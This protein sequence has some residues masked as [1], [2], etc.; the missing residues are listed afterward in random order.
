MYFDCIHQVCHGQGKIS[1]KWNFF[2]LREKSANFVDGQGN[3]E[4]TLKI[5][6]LDN[7]WLWQA[8]SRKFIFAVQERKGCTF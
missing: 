3:L 6:E 4:R 5:R 1:G 8:V 7:K 2:Q